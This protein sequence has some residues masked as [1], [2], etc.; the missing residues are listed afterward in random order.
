M[1]KRVPE[2][3]EN[4]TSKGFLYPIGGLCVFGHQSSS[5]ASIWKVMAKNNSWRIR[6]MK[7]LLCISV[8]VLSV[9]SMGTVANAQDGKYKIAVFF[10]H[11]STNDYMAFKGIKDGFKTAGLD[12]D[13]DIMKAFRDEDKASE[14]I[15]K[16]SKQ[17][18]DLIYAMGTHGTKRIMKIIKDTPIVFTA[19]TN[20]VQSGITPNWNTSGRNIAGNSNWIST[21]KVLTDFKEV[22]PALK[23]LGVI[24][25]PDNPVSS[26]E[27]RV[28]RKVVDSLQLKLMQIEVKSTDD[29]L[30]AAKSLVAKKVE[31]I[32]VPID[33]LVYNNLDKIRAVTDPAKLPLV[34]SSHKGIKD[35]AIFGA[36]VDY[37]ALGK[38][39]VSIALK[40]LDQKI[41][42]KDIPV[43][44]MHSYKHIFNFKIAK[45]IGYEIPLSVLAIADEIIE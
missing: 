15:Q 38:L 36:V 1:I 10:W 14:I 32:W 20:P 26:A 21:D 39:S 28:A 44:T 22:V 9:I 31:A 18:P 25:D 8:A 2:G 17:K 19:V 34:S 13:F 35:G 37:H 6:K 3:T 41:D 4:R 23:R 30:P 24:Y 11:E 5:M 42:P 12:C 27:V 40:I 45:E 43:G 33:R 7:K 29:L 16:L